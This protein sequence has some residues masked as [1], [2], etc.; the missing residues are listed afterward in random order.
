MGAQDI[1]NR[2]QWVD[3]KLMRPFQELLAAMQEIAAVEAQFVGKQQALAAL[4]SQVK[5]IQSKIIGKRDELNTLETSDIERITKKRQQFESDHTARMNAAD[6]DYNRKIGTHQ[7]MIAQ[8]NL[9]Q[10]ALARSVDSVKSEY[11]DVHRKL[12]TAH[13]RAVESRQAEIAALD[14]Q[15][16]TLKTQRENFLKE[17][18]HVVTS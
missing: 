16:L 1:V 15:I 2:L 3:E 5:D 6:Q 18:G 7:A 12:Q 14:K 4:E 9:E 17:V 11:G 8:L 13:D 10:A